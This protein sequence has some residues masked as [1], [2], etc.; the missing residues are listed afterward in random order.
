M[1]TSSAQ[2]LQHGTQRARRPVRRLRPSDIIWAICFS[3]CALVLLFYGWH[4]RTRDFTLTSSQE[5]VNDQ[6]DSKSGAEEGVR[7][8]SYLNAPILVSYA[9]YEK[10]PIQR[11]N[12]E[13][14]LQQGWVAP[15]LSHTS[16]RNKGSGSSRTG[17]SRTRGA[18]SSS[19]C[20]GSGSP[21]LITW[22]FVVAG[23]ACSPCSGTFPITAPLP[24]DPDIGV[25]KATRIVRSV[26]DPGQEDRIDDD[27]DNDATSGG[28]TDPRVISHPRHHPH[29][30]HAKQNNNQQQQQQQQQY[31]SSEK[32]NS[33]Q[34]GISSTSSVVT[35]GCPG[36]GPTYLLWRS[37]NVGMDFASHNVTLEYLMRHG[38]G[39]SRY[40]YIFLL[41]S[42]V[43]G[44]LFPAYLPPWWHWSHAFLERFQ[45]LPQDDPRWAPPPSLRV[46][47]PGVSY[48]PRAAS[49][50]ASGPSSAAAGDDGSL[51]GH[52]R[53]MGPPV[54]RAVG[55]SLV[56][57]P[58][59]D[60]GGPGPRLESWAVALDQEALQLAMKR[61]VF[62][63]RTCKTCEDEQEGIVVGGEY[64]L[65]A[66]L[67]EAGY[68]VATLMSKYARNVDWRDR[69]HW[70]CND[71]V[72]PSRHGT[73][74]GI[75]F[76]P[77]ETIFVKS[78]WHVADPYTRRYSTWV[79]QHKEGDAGTDG[80]WN[81]KL[82]RYAIS[83]RA[84]QPNLLEA[85]YNV[86][87]VQQLM[88][89]Q[90]E[91]EAEALEEEQRAARERAMAINNE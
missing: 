73:Y 60:A 43:R 32:I 69:R 74:D 91:A 52:H 15:P 62:R 59:A 5:K 39:L 57:L 48:L 24:A 71:M 80:E 19:S 86:E 37:E 54:V 9:Y 22:V 47:P 36:A 16:R 20:G 12:F 84:Q 27:N 13:F 2:T 33:K 6:L 72:H 75:G 68:N 35:D 78:S 34:A 44:P 70:G 11:A 25:V 26:E 28:G 14:F 82:Y 56:C 40:R 41:N 4:L 51:A 17:S 55:S 67:L 45:P 64:G 29:H 42:S 89:K 65:T 85:A 66:V 7:P 58:E 46:L 38:E 3:L 8:P 87:R 90:R 30:Q 18:S 63:I 49:S 53:P 79:T 61:G 77:Y 21:P 76:H 50:N 1:N 10:D 88:A 81:E 31:G 23:E 83:P